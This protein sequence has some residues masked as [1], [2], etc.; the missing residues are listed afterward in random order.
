MEKGF[1]ANLHDLLRDLRERDRRD[2]SRLLSPL[3]RAPGALELD[4]SKLSLEEAVA[5]IIAWYG[6]RVGVVPGGS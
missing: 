2:Q 6:E 3:E 1:S 4:T 5:A